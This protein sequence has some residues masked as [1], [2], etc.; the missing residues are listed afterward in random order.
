MDREDIYMSTSGNERRGFRRKLI[1]AL[2]TVTLA[3]AGGVAPHAHAYVVKD[4]SFLL[5]LIHI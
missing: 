5:S 1:A 2:S 4:D 3:V